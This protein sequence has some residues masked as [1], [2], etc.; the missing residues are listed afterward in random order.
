M[1][2][3]T[4][5][6][7]GYQDMTAEEKLAALEGYDFEAPAPNDDEIRRLKDAVSRANSE[8][9]GYKKQLRS[10]MSEDEAKAQQEAEARE[11]M[12]QELES[13]RKEKAIQGY[14][15]KFLE[16]GYDAKSAQEAAQAMQAGDFDAVFASQAKFIETAKKDAVANS[17]KGQPSLS[18]GEPLN[19]E[20]LEDSIVA[21]FR[22]A[23]L[24]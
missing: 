7:E 6:I 1:K 16:L 14:Q 19:K 22:K 13:L 21:S 11:A 4:S 3:D 10:K 17:L 24:S 12:Q 20:N 18:S 8:A 2:I 5:K 23:A 9:A 15:T